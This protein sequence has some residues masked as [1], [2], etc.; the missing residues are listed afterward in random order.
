[1]DKE[2]F[3]G[4][5]K[6]Y[7]D[8]QNILPAIGPEGGWVPFETELMERVGF[9]RFSLGRW[10]LRVETAVTAVLSQVELLRM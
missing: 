5:D 1:P 4:L 9:Q 3:R 2:T 10:T 8:Q 7:H 6:L